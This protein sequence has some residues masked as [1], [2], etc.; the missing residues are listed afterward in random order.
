MEAIYAKLQEAGWQ[1]PETLTWINNQ[2]EFLF[3]KKTE[4]LQGLEQGSGEA[5]IEFAPDGVRRATYLDLSQSSLLAPNEFRLR[6]VGGY[7]S[8]VTLAVPK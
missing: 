3:G 5:M 4:I 8:T 7:T 6:V 2:G 1:H